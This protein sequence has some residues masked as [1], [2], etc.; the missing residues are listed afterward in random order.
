[1]ANREVFDL[2]DA[3]CRGRARE[4]LARAGQATERQDPSSTELADFLAGALKNSATVWTYCPADERLDCARTAL[5]TTQTVG[6]KGVWHAVGLSGHSQFLAEKVN[7]LPV[8][9][10]RLKIDA[11]QTVYRDS[12]R[13]TAELPRALT[14]RAVP[15]ERYFRMPLEDVERLFAMA[16]SRA[17]EAAAFE[18]PW[19]FGVSSYEIERL[20]RATSWISEH[21]SPG[22][23][24][25]LEVG[26]C[27]GAHT[28]LLLDAGH[29][30]VAC[31]PAAEFR[32]RL[33]GRVRGAVPVIASTLE[34]LAASRSEPADAYLLLEMLYYLEDPAVVDDLPTDM[35]FISG[36]P[37]DPAYDAVHAWLSRSRVWMVRD[38]RQLI[39]PRFDFLCHDK[40]YQCKPGSL[41][42]FCTRRSS[43]HP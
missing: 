43:K 19:G 27:E 16:H 9:Q 33:I 31:E 2:H 35:I 25:L 42:L 28:D 26:S 5:L 23:G 12:V 10:V 11:A 6:G 21:V 36:P 14:E 32:R 40:V 4:V 18:D 22:S 38:Q 7:P 8:E 1:M 41:G 29:R 37:T 3:D 39:E 17:S 15:C 13:R 20:S 24:L 34:E 30:L